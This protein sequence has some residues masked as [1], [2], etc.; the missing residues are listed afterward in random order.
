MQRITKQYFLMTA[1]IFVCSIAVNA[2]Q[3]P[4]DKCFAEAMKLINAK[5][6]ARTDFI[7]KMHQSTPEDNN[8]VTVD[9]DQKINADTKTTGNNK[10]PTTNNLPI[11]INPSQQPI[12]I[13]K[14]PVL[15]R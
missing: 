3:K 11:T 12:R 13:P 15:L 4:S 14:K 9:T 10:T 6:A 7:R 1:V 2:Q 8:Q 5:K